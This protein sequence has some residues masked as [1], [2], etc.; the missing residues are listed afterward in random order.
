MPL[1]EYEE[2]KLVNLGTNR[3]TIRPQLGLE[4]WQGNWVF[5]VTGSIWFFTDNDDF[6]EGTKR[7]QDPLYAIQGHV[8]YNFKP[9]FWLSTG[10]G[11]GTGARTTI[12]GVARSDKQNNSR[13]SMTLGLPVTRHQAIKLLYVKGRTKDIG[14]DFQRFAIAW[15][16]MWGGGI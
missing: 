1:G 3:F 15:S 8:V 16:M 4:H 14:G 5:E 12:D 6:F 10:V 2:D 7:T 11:F 13:V 9:G